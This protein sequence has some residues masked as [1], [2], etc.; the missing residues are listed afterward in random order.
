[1]TS[2]TTESDEEHEDGDDDGDDKH[3]DDDK[4]YDVEPE[5]EDD[6]DAATVSRI[7]KRI[8]S[9]VREHDVLTEFVTSLDPTPVSARLLR[10]CLRRRLHRLW[11]GLFTSGRSARVQFGARDVQVAV[12]LGAGFAVKA[13]LR[14]R[15]RL[16]IAS[17]ASVKNDLYC[18]ATAPNVPGSVMEALLEYLGYEYL[19]A[20]PLFLVQHAVVDGN[21]DALAVLLAHPGIDPTVGT[22]VAIKTAASSSEYVGALHMLLA[23][24]RADPAVDDNMPLL[25]A[26][27]S[28]SLV[29]AQALLRDRRVHLPAHD[30]VAI[31]MAVE[32]CNEGMVRLLL[33]QPSVDP[34]AALYWCLE[35]SANE[36]ILDLLLRDPRVDVTKPNKDGLTAVQYLHRVRNATLQRR[37][38][39]DPVVAEQRGTCEPYALP[40]LDQ[41]FFPIYQEPLGPLD[42]LYYAAASGHETAVEEGLAD[43]RLHVIPGG[44]LYGL[45]PFNAWKQ[46]AEAEAAAGTTAGTQTSIK[47]A[48]L[49]ILGHPNT[50][51]TRCTLRW[52]A[53]DPQVVRAILSHPRFPAPIASEHGH[54]SDVELALYEVLDCDPETL[55][56]ALEHPKLQDA[57][58]TNAGKV[59]QVAVGER[60]QRDVCGQLL[61]A[62]CM[63][64]YVA[65]HGFSML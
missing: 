25:I 2:C 21:L 5:S 49:R 57:W 9:T 60:T 4:K 34:Q 47:K 39:E 35:R 59:F 37:L 38:L 44:L 43:P 19:V 33:A 27:S 51:V 18:M 26:V 29:C 17:V 13:M 24:G 7:L 6:E 11:D 32:A 48:T 41:A 10:H 1:M 42:K 65:A 52:L 28:G 22:N 62:P 46:Q 61:A 20:P 30:S 14:D 50:A 64:D 12:E 45:M 58:R 40:A 63:H 36:S 15:H 23:D 16:D 3:E 53:P 54:A 55:Q 56:F 31:V 8:N